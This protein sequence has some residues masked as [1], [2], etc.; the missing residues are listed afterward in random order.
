MGNGVQARFRSSRGM[1]LPFGPMLRPPSTSEGSTSTGI[2]TSHPSNQQSAIRERLGDSLVS[3]I[4]RYRGGGGGGGDS[5]T[6]TT[7]ATTTSGD[8]IRTSARTTPSNSADALSAALNNS[9]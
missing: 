8:V 6:T 5:T 3:M 4:R 9:F 2:T 1:P 7:T